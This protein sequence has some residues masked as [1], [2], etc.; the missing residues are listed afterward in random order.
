MG[1][2]ERPLVSQLTSTGRNVGRF[3]KNVVP[4]TLAPYLNPVSCVSGQHV[5]VGKIG[6]RLIPP[7]GA[8]SNYTDEPISDPTQ[9]DLG[10]RTT[11]SY[12]CDYVRHRLSLLGVTHG[13]NQLVLPE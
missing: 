8:T 11:E 13:L 6:L 7:N 4:E 5:T 3:N 1:S 2:R 9:V 12:C 10:A